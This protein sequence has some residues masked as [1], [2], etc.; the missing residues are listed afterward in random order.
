MFERLAGLE[1]EFEALEARMG[2]IYSSGDQDAVRDAGK[3]HSELKPIVD[4]FRE[5]RSAREQLDEAR[6]MARSEAAETPA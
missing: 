1:Q 4:T 6:E 2:D 5:L 3:R